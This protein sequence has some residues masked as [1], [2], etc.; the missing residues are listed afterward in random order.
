MER[1]E[2]CMYCT[3]VNVDLHCTVL[4]VLHNVVSLVVVIR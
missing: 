3:Y 1:D 2:G 4:H